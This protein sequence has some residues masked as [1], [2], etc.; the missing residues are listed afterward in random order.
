MN[1]SCWR[2]TRRSFLEYVGIVVRVWTVNLTLSFSLNASDISTI[3]EFSPNGLDGSGLA[4][5]PLSSSNESLGDA[6]NGFWSIWLDA[7]ASEAVL[8]ALSPLSPT[9]SCNGLPFALSYMVEK[10]KNRI[11][12]IF[13]LLDGIVLSNIEIA[14]T[15]I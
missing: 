1:S 12:Q 2:T 4:C 7:P 3:N 5:W 10:K 6:C 9:S 8:D 14:E 15:P 11:L 13:L